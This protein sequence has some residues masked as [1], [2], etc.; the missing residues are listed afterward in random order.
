[1]LRKY[2][3]G[4]CKRRLKKEREEMLAKLPKMTNF[5]SSNQTIMQFPQTV[6]NN[7]NN[8]RKDENNNT[9]NEVACQGPSNEIQEVE[10]VESTMHNNELDSDTILRKDP[11]LWPLQLNENELMNNGEKC[12]RK[13]LMFSESTGCVFCYVCKLFSTDYDNVFVKSGFYNWKKAK[14]TIFG[15]ENSKEH[16]QCMIKWIEFIKQNT[17]V[18]E[19]MASQ[20]KREFNYW[21]AILNRIV[22]V[23]RFLAGR[24]LAF[25]GHNEVIGSSN[26]GNYL[27]MLEL[28]TQFD[29][30]LKQHIDTFANKGKG[31]VNYLSKTICEELIDIMSQKVLTHIITEIKKAKYWGIIVGSTP[32]ISHVDQLS[33]IFRYCLNGNVYE[34]FF[35]FLQIKSHDGK[36]LITDILDLLERYTG[37]AYDNASNMSGKYS[38]LQARLKERSELAFYIPCAGHSLNLVGQCSVSE[39]INSINY[40]GVLQSLYSFFVASTH[41]WD[42]LKGNYATL[43]RLSDTRWSCRSDASKSL[44]ENFN[45]IHAAL[46]HIAED[47][48]EKSDTRHEALCLLNKITKLEFALMA[49]L[50]H[51]ILKRFNAVSKFLQKVEFDSHTASSMLLSLIDFVKNLRNDFTRFQN[52]SKKLSSFIEK[53]YS[54]KNKRKV[55]KKLSNGE[56]QVDSLSVSDKFRVNTFFVIVDKLVTQLTIRSDGYNHVNKLFGFLSK[57]LT[58]S[59][60]ELQVSAKKI[61][62]V[63]SIDLEDSFIFEIEQFLTLLKLQPPGFFSHKKDKSETEN[64]LI[65]LHVLNW[66]VETDIIDVFPNFYIAYRL[67]LTISITNCEAERSFS[68]L[69]RVKNMHRSTMV[70]S[71]LS[72]IARLTIESKLLE[73]LDFSNVIAEFAGKK[74]RKK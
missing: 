20:I 6:D 50:W 51:H 36:S 67:F 31:N 5:F 45:G 73:T 72:N 10:S 52:E 66:I 55:I 37:Q 30:V 59:T 70:H 56:S 41:R 62:E 11:A 71:R 61:V 44:V 24:G 69:K 28:L 23:I 7:K 64:T 19:Y 32:D 35:C 60:M 58:I 27:G 13:W 40:Y 2:E 4:A 3:S 74:S 17:H 68:T 21:S 34:R 47:T 1:M 33:V 65:P 26:N 49:V 22:A 18:D 43:K 9:E 25:R 16:I 38:G 29:P 46:C 53:D 15:H 8:E 39:C 63:Y 54:D 42:L 48:E 14:Q 57:P 12:D